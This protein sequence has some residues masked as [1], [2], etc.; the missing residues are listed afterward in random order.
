MKK[1][2][3]KFSHILLQSKSSLCSL[4]MQPLII[5]LFKQMFNLKKQLNMKKAITVLA[6]LMTFARAEAQI[7]DPTPY[8]NFRTYSAYA[9]GDPEDDI[10]GL[11]LNTINRTIAPSD[12][13]Y[14][15]YNSGIATTLNCGTSYPITINFIKGD[16]EYMAITVFIDYNHNNIFDSDEVAYNQNNLSVQ[17]FDSTFTLNGNVAVP[18][19]A[20][21][22]TTRLRI[23]IMDVTDTAASTTANPCAFSGGPYGPTA[24]NSPFYGEAID[25]NVNITGTHASGV[26]NIATQDKVIVY[27]NPARGEVSISEDFSAAQLSITNMQGQLMQAYR[28]AGRKI[29]ISQLAPGNY[30]V[31]LIKGG[32]VYTQLLS[33]E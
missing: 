16:I 18:L 29:D 27:P 22:G 19:T 11:Q 13:C 8:C 25:Y 3:L 10:T 21:A 24:D 26:E 31:R 15:Y 32:N 9:G 7:Y 14:L 17:S 33:V 6:V 20:L 1:L 30:F 4:L 28:I 12:S 23:M 2:K 5:N